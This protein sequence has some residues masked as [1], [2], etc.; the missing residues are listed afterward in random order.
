M[1]YL[2]V[3]QLKEGMILGQE[4]QD[5]SGRMLLEKHT[6]LSK[7]NI[8]YISFLEVSGI[9]IE[10]DFSKDVEIKEVIQPEVKKVSLHLVSEIFGQLTDES[11]MAETKDFQENVQNVV[12]NVL[13]NRDVVYNLMEVRTYDNY[14]Y[15]HSVNVGVLSGVIGAKM[16]LVEEE[17]QKAVTAGFLHD[18]GKVFVAPELINAPR[19]LNEE[20]RI[21]MMDHPR[22]GSSFLSDNYRFHPDVTKAVYE[23]HEWY[24]GGGY[25]C[26][27]NGRETLLISRIIKA[28]DVYDA[29][30]S[31]RPYHDAYLPSEV[32]EYIMGRSGME[33]DPEIVKTMV[34][35]LCVYPVGCEVELSNGEKALVIE[36]HKGYSLR[37]TVKLMSNGREL[38]LTADRNAWNLTIVKLM[39]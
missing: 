35:E 10:D 1:R 31:K 3:S 22:E 26:R 11:D 2:P 37:P 19:R 32:L 16:G 39:V 8:S 6:R 21:R 4:L 15:F 29:M 30:T 13:D 38:D 7:E 33:F 5:A 34:Q 25:P 24:D 23:H 36:N 28:A 9:Y 12:S 17:L 27:K 20:E 14:T 18:I